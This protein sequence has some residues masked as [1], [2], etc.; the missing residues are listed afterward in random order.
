MQNVLGA[1]VQFVISLIVFAVATY[2]CYKW[3]AELKEA[4]K[5]PHFGIKSCVCCC[6][7]TIL[8]ICLPIDETETE[9]K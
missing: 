2:L 4:G 8:A 6:C 7:C 5:A 1:T 9:S 3:N